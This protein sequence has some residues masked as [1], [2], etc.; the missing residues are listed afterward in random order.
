MIDNKRRQTKKP[1]TAPPPPPGPSISRAPPSGP[2]PP[3][4]PAPPPPP[5]GPG[6]A[7][8][9]PPPP[10]GKFY[11]KTPTYQKAT[12]VQCSGDILLS[13]LLFYQ[14]E[15][16]KNRASLILPSSIARNS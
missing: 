3:P 11:N 8:G 14:I 10:S 5:P 4:A 1:V 6:P 15:P 9:P 16:L 12:S 13:T 7:P 2:P